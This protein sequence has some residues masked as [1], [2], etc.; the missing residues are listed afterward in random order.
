MRIASFA[1]VLLFALVTTSSAQRGNDYRRVHSEG[2]YINLGMTNGPDFADFFNQTNEFYQTRF[3]NTD[4]ELERFGKGF[5]VGLGYLVRLYPNFA[6]DVGFSIYRLKST[7][8]IENRNLTFPEPYVR[9]ELEYQVGIFS[10][11]IPVLLDFDPRQ[12]AVPYVGIGVSIF[13]MRLDDYRN[14]GI[15]SEILRETNTSV[16]GH[17]ETGLFVKISKRIWVDFKARWHSG[18][19]NLRT[20]EPPPLLDMD[21]YKMKQDIAQITLGGV[22]YFR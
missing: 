20:L 3:L 1:T 11:T 9:H 10:A 15:N 21:K 22:Y 7:G 18:S 5:N 6:L 8:T 14:D 4:E 17:F 12:P 2:F 16:G 19:A 13:S